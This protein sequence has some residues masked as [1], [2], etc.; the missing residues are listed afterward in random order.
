GVTTTTADAEGEVLERK[1]VA[2]GRAEIVRLL[3]RFVGSQTQVPPMYSAL[4][5][6][7][8][9]LYVLARRGETIERTPRPIEIHSLDLLSLDANRLAIRVACS[10]GTYIR[11]L[12]EDIGAAL[13]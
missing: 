1:P 13:G 12:G 10:K 3:S 6:D 11:T 7:G 2:A 5:R 8:T 4:K 9:P